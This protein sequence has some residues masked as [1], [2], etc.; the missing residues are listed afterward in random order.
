MEEFFYHQSLLSAW[1]VITILLLSL[2]A[3]AFL[4][5]NLRRLKKTEASLRASEQRLRMVL[6]TT[7]QGFYDLDCRTGEAWGSPEY[8]SMLGYENVGKRIRVAEW[9]AQL[10]PEDRKMALTMLADCLNGVSDSYQLEYRFRGNNDLWLWVQSTGKVVEYDEHNKPLRILGLHTDITER[11]NKERILRE[12]EERFRTVFELSSDGIAYVDTANHELFDANPAMSRLLGRSAKDIDGLAFEQ[13]HPRDS[14]ASIQDEFAK[15]LNVA[16]GTVSHDIPILR[17]DGVIR[18]AD[19]TSTSVTLQGKKLL[20]GN[21]RDITERKLTEDALKASERKF[22]EFYE[23]LMDA[24]VMVDMT[25]RLVEYNRTYL[26][27]TGYQPE[28]LNK[29]THIDL[30]PESWHSLEQRII[31]EQVIPRGYSAV[32]EK[33]YRR[34]DGSIIPIELRTSLLRD[35]SGQPKG[36]WAIVRDISERK[37]VEATLRENEERLRQAVRVSQLGIFEHD[38]RSDMVYVSPEQRK[39]HGFADE[40]SVTL[41]TFIARMHPDDLERIIAAIQR[42]HDPSGNGLFDIEHRIILPSGETRWIIARS[43][44]FFAGEGNGR[45]PVRTVGAMMDITERK[46]AENRQRSLAAIVENSLNEIY[47]FDAKTFCF[48]EANQGARRNLGYTQAELRSLTTLDI[49]PE[50]TRESYVELVR[51]VICGELDRLQYTTTH[52][53]K[54]GTLYPVE[55]N[56][57]FSWFESSPALVVIGLDITERLQA[58]QAL[59]QSEERYREAQHTAHLGHWSFDTTTEQFLW[60]S[61]ETFRLL[62]LSSDK[63]NPSYQTFIQ[64]V[65]P[66]DRQHF[67]QL[68]AQSVATGESFKVSY[69]VPQNEGGAHFLEARWIAHKD[70]NGKVCRLFGTVMDITDRTLAEQSL[71]ES[72]QK[73]RTVAENAQAV[74]FILDKQGVFLLSE[75]LGLAA[76]GLVPGQVV[77][78]SALELYRDYPGVLE[79]IRLALAGQAQHAI[80][81]LPGASFDTVYTPLYNQFGELNGVVGIAIDITEREIAK[82]ALQA[83]ERF[84]DAIIEQS[85]HSMWIS[86]AEGTMIRM[87]QACRDLFQVTDEELVGKYN[88]FTDNVL[89]SQGMMPLVKQVFEN[90][91][92]AKFNIVY[93]TAELE[94]LQL[95]NVTKRILETTI[96]PVL[97]TQQ[98]LIN[99]IV[100]HVDLSDRIRAETALRES[101]ARLS[102]AVESIP[103]DFFL[104]DSNGRYVL[105]NSVSKRLWGDVT[106]RRPEDVTQDPNTLSV[107]QNN[108]HRAFAGEV[109]NK[110]E[111]YL[112]GAELRYVHNFVGPVRSK[113]GIR[114]IVGLNIDVTEQKRAQ[115]ALSASITQLRTIITNAPI[116]LF[117]FDNLGVFTL[118]EGKGLEGMGLKSGEI[119][120]K[121]A[122]DLYRDRPDMLD[123]IKRAI[124]GESFTST[125]EYLDH[126]FEAHHNKLIDTEGETACLGILVDITERARAEARVRGLNDELEHRVLERT[127][128]LAETNKQLTQALETL[129]KAQEEL[130]RSEK[131]AGLGSLVAGVAHE[132]NTPLGVSLTAISQFQEKTFAINRSYGSD[133]LAQ[134]EFEYYLANAGKTTEIILHNIERAAGLIRSFKQVAVDQTSEETRLIDLKQYFHMVVESLKPELKKG[135]HRVEIDCPE[136]IEI[137]TYPG[138]L[139]QI[140]S[141]LVINSVQ[142]GFGEE[143]PGGLISIQA[144][145]SDDAVT[146]VYRDNGRGMSKEVMARIFEPFFTTSRSK[147]GSGLGLSIVYNLVNYKLKGKL[148]C[149]S[150]PNL[151]MSMTLVFPVNTTINYDQGN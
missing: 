105:Q 7:N 101:E 45:S 71:R 62:G 97:D 113:D 130:I 95:Q 123:N 136:K 38:H 115:E 87:N 23:S 133:N 81:S 66:D 108:N 111:Q 9:E 117:S 83:S 57:Q 151:G 24:Y 3:I 50:F 150:T 114:G 132:L 61:E 138:Y 49:K 147:G 80:N 72:E 68:V 118:S 122:F 125:F 63:G 15:H 51:P 42:A 1:T 11:K 55:V 20:V 82:Q 131:L 76:L 128:E 79:N 56:L 84:L 135:Q 44:T 126:V 90:K 69:R 129:H 37:R 121:S 99:A 93:D 100:Q 70:T 139:A 144:S 86:N 94:S 116:V 59:K 77:G 67:N 65:H 28:E 88:L 14:L 143:H 40:C 78:Q 110:V 16:D 149:L 142:H 8:F 75:G 32:Y 27:L 141:N 137:E 109:I 73:F 98:H 46:L 89:E 33:E 112:V 29:L 36:M 25:G 74:I 134:E 35:T 31:E 148:D 13:I 18:Y 145:Y 30:T 41:A 119:V 39:I 17:A 103:F 22:R 96:S 53:R 6:A 140:L 127:T 26:S 124:A 58:E 60:W 91:V 107:W 10:Y 2:L 106:G 19:I 85:P 43:Q 104:M 34:K 47:I 5:E 102:A 146:V 4:W 21:F 52:R 92:Q 12:S 48:L 64:Q 120:G 54:D